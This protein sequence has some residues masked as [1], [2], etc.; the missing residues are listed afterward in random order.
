MA[1]M[2]VKAAYKAPPV[3]I[4]NSTGFISAAS[5]TSLDLVRV[6]MSKKF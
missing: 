6:G 5:T 1:D 2:P 3:E 4:F